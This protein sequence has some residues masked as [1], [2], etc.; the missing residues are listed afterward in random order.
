MDEENDEVYYLPIEYHVP[1]SNQ[2][3]N[4][5][6]RVMA[7]LEKSRFFTNGEFLTLNRS[8]TAVITRAVILD[9]KWN[10]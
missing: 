1:H 6:T 3:D 10:L 8:L 4:L 5:Q 9:Y 7:A 2:Y